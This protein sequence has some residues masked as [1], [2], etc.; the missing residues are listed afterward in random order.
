MNLI[1]RERDFSSGD[2]VEKRSR[3]EGFPLSYLCLFFF[4]AFFC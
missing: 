3:R 2:R 1:L 4:A